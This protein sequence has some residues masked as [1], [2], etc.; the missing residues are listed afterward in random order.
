MN[1][2]HRSILARSLMAGAASLAF[3]MSSRGVTR[4]LTRSVITRE[5]GV[6]RKTIKRIRS[7]KLWK[8]LQ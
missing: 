5:C 8:H 3:M 1:S 6:D 2:I 7:R 4:C